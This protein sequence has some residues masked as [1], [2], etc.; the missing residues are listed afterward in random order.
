VAK[1]IRRNSGSDSYRGLKAQKL[2]KGEYRIY[3][4]RKVQ[5]DGQ[6]NQIA[7]GDQRG[8]SHRHL[9]LSF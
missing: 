5:G 4:R 3:Y 2:T 8:D 6:G 1:D 7:R 9:E